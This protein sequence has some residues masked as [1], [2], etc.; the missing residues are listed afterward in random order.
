MHRSYKVALGTSAT[1]LILSGIGALALAQSPPPGGPPPG[2]PPP[3]GPP[4][5]MSQ[6]PLP[7][8]KGPV[9]FVLDPG[10]TYPT[11][12]ADHRGIST[13]MGKFNKTTGTVVL[14]RTAKTG[15]V[16][17][18]VDIGSINF[19][20]EKMNEHALSGDMFDVTKFATATYSGK[21]TKFNGDVPTEVSGNLTLHGV[22]KPVKLTIT[23]FACKPG[24]GVG[25]GVTCGGDA[26]AEFNR[27]DFGISFGVPMGMDPNTR[28]MIQVEGAQQK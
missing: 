4:P 19:G 26:T 11:F 2:G 23:R 6:A 27:A 28:L 3:G 17:V 24:M 20:H 8:L 16:D 1:A 13:W 5:A 18:T 21:F 12:F 22:T 25:A 15:T 9:T 14:D 10:H 7:T